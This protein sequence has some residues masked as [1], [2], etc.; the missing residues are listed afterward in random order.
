[1]Q[2]H[3]QII[4]ILAFK[5]NYIWLIHDGKQAV[6]IDPGEAMP[7]INV[8]E[9]L[10]LTLNT[11]LITHHH[12][13]HIDG[14]A[15]LIER[16]PLIKVYAPKREQYD[17]KH[18]PVCEPD[19]ININILGLRLRVIDCAGHTSGHIAYYAQN[20]DW[21]LSGDVIFAAG[22]GF[23]VQNAYQQAFDSL[24]KIAN[25][26]PQTQIFCTHEYTL[27]NIKF[28]RTLEPNNA[29][30]LQRQQEVVQLRAQNQ[31]TLP[32]TVALELATNPFLRYNSPELL[33]NI[34]IKSS[35]PVEIFSTIRNIKNN[36]KT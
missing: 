8:L 31:P 35:N 15:T 20:Q 12:H 25:L 4:P 9:K 26:P 5:D 21:L 23:V 3:L 6:V 32:T 2:H 14:V 18:S 22:C 33:T 19:T 27:N 28:A 34:S 24:Q 29:L 11:I 36:Y 30:L 1:M 7:V 17:F 10:H 16:Y 13:D